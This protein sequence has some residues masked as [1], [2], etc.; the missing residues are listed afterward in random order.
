MGSRVKPCSALAHCA[1]T[2][3]AI[4]PN[5]L[6]A[7]QGSLLQRVAMRMLMFCIRGMGVLVLQQFV[8]VRVAV[9]QMRRATVAL[10]GMHMVWVRVAMAV[11]MLN[12]NMDMKMVMPFGQH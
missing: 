3:V 5:R 10:M 6:R 1:L 11:G 12:R 4:N 9:R 2:R 7:A 8:A